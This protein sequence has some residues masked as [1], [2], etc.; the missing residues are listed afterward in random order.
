L[1]AERR[2]WT[3]PHLTGG[4]GLE[5][6]CGES[7][8]P[9]E[10]MAA[11]MGESVEWIDEAAAKAEP[12]AGGLF[13]VDPAPSRVGDFPL[14]RTGALS[15]P[16]PLLALARSRED[17]ARAVLEGIAFAAATGLDWTADVAG[18]AEEV[19]L[20]GGVARSRAFAGILAAAL[21]RP[22]SV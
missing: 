9:V 12:G 4:F 20:T 17:V 14:M 15:F 2:L 3:S 5:A 1:D 8:V 13:F 6:H 22:I 7:G 19:A 21:N 10:W 18:P 11:L 16:A